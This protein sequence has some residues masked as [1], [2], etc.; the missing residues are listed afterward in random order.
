MNNTSLLENQST[1]T[2]VGGLVP[3]L[4]RTLDILE[5]LSD[6]DAGMTL[7]ALS[8][9]LELPKNAV[10]RITQTLW[11]ADI[12]TEMKKAWHFR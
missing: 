6:A 4:D 8:Q 1:E 12:F 11:P 9:E 5:T 3:A 7:S 2:E 10:F